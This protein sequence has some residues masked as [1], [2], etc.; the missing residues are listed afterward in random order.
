MPDGERAPDSLYY[1]GQ[2][3][4][5]LKKPADACK[6]Y[7]ELSDVYGDKISAGMKADI[8]KARRDA[9]CR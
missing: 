5:Q 9:Q 3:L 6:V 4:M 8:A 7:S 1:L 2:A